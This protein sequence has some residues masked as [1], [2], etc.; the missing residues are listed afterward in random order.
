MR[1]RFVIFGYEV[2]IR[3]ERE[4]RLHISDFNKEDMMEEK[5]EHDF[6]IN[7]RIHVMIKHHGFIEYIFRDFDIALISFR[8]SAI[9]LLEDVMKSLR[10]IR[11]NLAIAG[12]TDEDLNKYDMKIHECF[13]KTLNVISER[14]KN[15]QNYQKESDKELLSTLESFKIY[16]YHKE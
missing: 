9:M 15:S 14:I 8:E 16:E 3:P 6:N 10:R 11:D 4:V 12:A 1:I 13:Q 7:K 5:W 2:R